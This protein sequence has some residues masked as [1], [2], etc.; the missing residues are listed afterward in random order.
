MSYLVYARKYRPEKFRAVS[1]QEHVTRTLSN[2]IRSERVAH[3]Y[4][5]TGPRGVGK[6]SIARIFAKAL[7]C[8]KGLNPEPCLTCRNCKEITA[9]TSLAV[10]EIDGASHNSVDNVRELIESFRSL[11][12]PGYRY[13]V[14]I[15]DEVHMLSTSAFNALLKSLE[16]PPPQTVL[17]FA[18]TEAHKIPDT[19]L[20]RCQR[21]D[22]RTLPAETIVKRLD[23]IAQA[24]KLS[25]A[26][27]ALQMVAR[28]ARGSLR[29]AQSLLDRVVAFSGDETISPELAGIALGTASIQALR[30]LAR[31]ILQRDVANSL[32]ILRSVFS[33]GADP[34]NICNELA[35]TFRE[36][37]LVKFG[38][39]SCCQ[40]LGLEPSLVEDLRN[41][42]QAVHP[43]DLQDLATVARSGL[44][45]ALRSQYTELALEAL[46]IRLASREPITKLSEI[47]QERREAAK[48]EGSSASKQKGMRAPSAQKKVSSEDS[49]KTGGDADFS[50]FLEHL[51]HNTSRILAEQLKLASVEVFQVPLLR[52]RLPR[53]LALSFEK[54]GEKSRIEDALKEYTPGSDW[55]VEIVPGQDSG[56]AEPGSIVHSRSESERSAREKTTGNILS[57]PKMKSI[58]KM[59]PG[60]EIEIGEQE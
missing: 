18:T 57:H 58:T 40:E 51:A 31:S 47:L 32:E 43:F 10:R 46:V 6:T 59:F 26:P 35:E 21:F 9:G 56:G 25:I 1:G 41:S 37:L 33:V 17:I 4:L 29:D 53:H 5:L 60:S 22:L 39:A 30:D 55:T 36:L 54:V 3:A 11:S 49:T 7:N 14:Y 45:L 27:G 15:I 13:K 38:D 16:E 20:S 12:P 42:T 19:V 34:T 2:A 50:S 8:E 52:L 28:L 44:D 24:E 48:G 23:E